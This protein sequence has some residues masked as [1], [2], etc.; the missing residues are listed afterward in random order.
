MRKM[1]IVAPEMSAVVAVNFAANDWLKKP[2]PDGP[3]LQL[4]TPRGQ[5]VQA[6]VLLSPTSSMRGVTTQK[7]IRFLKQ[8][9][10]SLLVCVGSKD[11]LDRR[12][13]KSV[14]DRL[15]GSHK[16][17][18]GMYFQPYD[19]IKLRGTDL[20]VKGLRTE[21]HII[22]FLDAHLKKLD[23]AWRDRRNQQT[24]STR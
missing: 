15:G 2:Y 1:A 6:L 12:Q 9:P 23:T 11:S 22:G 18:V 14:F 21:A 7:A 16:K 3:T 17:G 13:A 10:F 8:I 20:L 24:I 5:D 4:S 19:K